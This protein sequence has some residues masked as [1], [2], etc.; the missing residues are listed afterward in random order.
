MFTDGTVYECLN[1]RSVRLTK[2]GS[3]WHGR[4]NDEL[5]P[6]PIPFDAFGHPMTAELWAEDWSIRYEDGKPVEAAPTQL[7]DWY[8][9]QMGMPVT[10]VRI[11]DAPKAK[12][13]QV[14]GDHYK[15]MAIQPSEFI[16]ANNIGWYEGNAIKYI[17]RHSRKNGKIDLDKAKHYIDLLIERTY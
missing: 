14:G 7:D 15:D 6:L 12:D 2:F 8:G 5:D 3:Y 16:V 4:P 17:C 1:G 11:D 13:R 9:R 10:G